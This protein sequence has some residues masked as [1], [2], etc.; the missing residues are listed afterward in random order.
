MNDIERQIKLEAKESQLID[1]VGANLQV[2]QQ[3]V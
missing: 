1:E 2:F 3:H